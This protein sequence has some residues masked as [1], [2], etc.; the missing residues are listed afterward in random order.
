MASQ[1]RRQWSAHIGV[2]LYQ[3]AAWLLEPLA[4]F[5]Q[6]IGTLDTLERPDAP[7]NP[8]DRVY[9]TAQLVGE[10]EVQDEVVIVVEIGA[11]STACVSGT[12]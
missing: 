2:V 11:G 3:T 12:K 4:Y 1:D 6:L 9:T 7:D 10:P 5:L 8:A